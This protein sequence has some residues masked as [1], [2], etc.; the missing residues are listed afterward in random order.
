LFFV[1]IIRQFKY[2]FQFHAN[3]AIFLGI[4]SKN[5]LIIDNYDSFTQN[6]HHLLLRI[7]PE[8]SFTVLR[9]RD[10][11]I[12]EKT[13]DALIISPGPKGP[14]DTG[15]LKEFFEKEILPNNKPMLGVCLGMQFLAWYYGMTISPATDA[16]HGRTVLI[17]VKNEDLFSGIKSPVKV[18]RYNS[19]AIKENAEEIELSTPLQVTAIQ[20][21][22]S[23]VMALKHRELPFS[24]MQFHPESFLTEEADLMIDNFFKAFI[25]D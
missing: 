22:S 17:D 15:L 7:R 11:S 20:K 6:L 16:R 5:I 12:F 13:W 21:D 3:S 9:N 24:A 14:A 8:Y 1:K 25:D 18:V 4:M 19:L 2:S 23:M 10:G